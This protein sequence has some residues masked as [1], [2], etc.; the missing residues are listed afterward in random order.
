MSSVI[1]PLVY[2]ECLKLVSERDDLAASDLKPIMINEVLAVE[3]EL[4]TSLPEQYEDFLTKVGAGTEYGG[5][6]TWYHL[7]LTRHGNLLQRNKDLKR[8]KGAER[9]PNG[10]FA[11][12]DP[13]DGS[14]IG[15]NRSNGVFD[16]EI[17][18]WSVEEGVEVIADD[19]CEFLRDN[20][21]CSVAE[22]EKATRKVGGSV[23]VAVAPKQ[24]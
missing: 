10:F 21:D 19:F 1:E 16:P 13:C 14:L 11:I 22:I 17:V 18:I 2:L 8:N 24:A 9:S 5:L 12:Y 7:D 15:F 23:S 4:G 6:S 3:D 20:V